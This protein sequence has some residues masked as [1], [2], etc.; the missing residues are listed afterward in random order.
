MPRQLV[1]VV[2]SKSPAGHFFV[3]GKS[4]K[5]AGPLLTVAGKSPI[6]VLVAEEWR[7]P[8]AF[9]EKRRRGRRG[10]TAL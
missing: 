9:A 4:P 6:D 5:S 1:P 8:Q 7:P 2:A 3:A 10:A